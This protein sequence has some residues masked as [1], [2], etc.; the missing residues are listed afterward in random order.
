MNEENFI[1]S[2]RLVIKMTR[3]FAKLNLGNVVDSNDNKR[4]KK[5]DRNVLTFSSPQSFTLKTTN[6]LKNWDGT[7]E[8]S[9]DAIIWNVWSGDAQLHSSNDGLLYLRGTAN[10]VISKASSWSLSGNNISC[11]GNI[12]TL[13]DYVMVSNGEHPSMA[14]ACFRSMFYNCTSIVAAPKLPA[15]TLTEQCYRDMFYGCTSLTTAPELSATTLADTCCMEM[16]Y[17]CTSLTIAPELPAT[18]L[19]PSCYRGMFENCTSLVVPPEL[20]A[21]TLTKDCY[22]EMFYGCTSL[23]VA[24]ELPA[25]TLH[26]SC[27][28]AMFEGCTSLTTAPELPATTMVGNEYYRMFKDCTSLAVPPE[29]PATTLEVGCYREMFRGC[30]YLEVLPEL[31]ATKLK[32]S[33]YNGMFYGCTKIKLS[34]EQNDEYITPYRIPKS[35]TGRTANGALDGM[36]TNT[37]GTFASAPSINTTYYTSNT[38][39]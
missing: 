1:C 21:T 23:T 6:S 8:Y 20:P 17:G 30:T 12:E 10:T 13:L 35:G 24:P 2:K 5:I 37:G 4:F 36:F 31:P 28:Y 22:Q 9:T 38:V 11:K 29:L 19:A 3:K 18:T 16:F 27:Y 39:V 15:T 14:N 7:I 32:T 26:G 25:T 34:L 33:C